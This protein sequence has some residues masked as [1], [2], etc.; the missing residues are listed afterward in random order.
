MLNVKNTNHM[1]AHLIPTV[2]PTA[3]MICQLM[4]A[5]KELERADGC[6]KEGP[7]IE[8]YKHRLCERIEF[9]EKELKKKGDL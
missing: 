8:R 7:K 1:D 6:G 3:K 2:L 4:N 9:L 5:K